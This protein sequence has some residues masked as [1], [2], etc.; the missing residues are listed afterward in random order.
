MDD[1]IAL[2]KERFRY[3][4]EAE[5]ENREGALEDLRF[6]DGEQWPDEIKTEREKDGRPCL[7][8]NRVP[9]YVRQIV[10]DI[11]Q[12]RPSIKVR[13]VDSQSDPETAEI[14]NGMIRA[15]EQD[16]S[17]EAAYDWAAE[18]AVKAGFGFWRI[19]TEY[20]YEDSFDQCI[21]IGRVRNPFSVYIDPAA[22]AQ[23]ASDMRYAFI[24]DRMSKSA[25]EKKYPGKT[26][27]WD[28]STG[29]DD[30][31]FGEDFVRVA[32]YWSVDEEE[33]TLYLIQD[34][35]T[36]EQIKTTE[37]P[38]KFPEELIVD[39][40]QTQVKKVVQRIMTGAE[41]LEENEWPGKYIPIVRVL[42]REVDIEG[43]IRL[44][45]I[46]RDLRDP[47]KMYNYMRSSGVERLA[48]TSKSPWIG[49]KGTFKNPKW[50]TANRANYAYLE[51]D[52]NVPPQREP[53][54]DISPGFV[55]EIATASEELKAITGIYDAGIGARSNEVSGIAIDNRRSESD[56]ANFDFVDNLA[57]AMTY[58]GKVLVDLIPKIYTGARMVR[59]LKPDGNDEAVQLNAPYIDQKTQRPKQYM[60]EAGKYDVAVD[61]GPGYATQRKEAAESMIEILKAFPQAA[62]VMGDLL[63]K[64]FDWPEADEISKRLKLLLPVE[65][66]Q[67]EN[68][69]FK[70]AMMQKEQQ[71]AALTQQSQALMTEL[72][73]MTVEM[74]N[75]MVDA[76]VKE[77]ELRRKIAKD[78]MDHTVDMTDLELQASRDL[79][80]YGVAY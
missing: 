24:V 29:D 23:D 64:N 9:L 46:V 61:I 31:W 20:E 57:R 30:W 80:P 8:I 59:I 26:G 41:V 19:Y 22:E 43:E 36:G 49:P 38:P 73:R 47:Q 39:K 5:A 55:N 27:S 3:A 18:Y 56:V 79:N 45:G 28:V 13:P 52:G 10:N 72:Q 67:D 42:G 25:F 54:P 58:A 14:I 17:A 75:K 63:A 53:P 33:Q 7:T 70:Q 66:L 34:P 40:R 16:S 35:M 6:A 50:R 68:P 77:G 4:Q 37:L 65:V 74:Q 32:E 78:L 76:K 11:R 15:I 69:A 60:L 21:K 51:Y 12:V 62:Q 71:I 2:A 1:V 44:K 48:L